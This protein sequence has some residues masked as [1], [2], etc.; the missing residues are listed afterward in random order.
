MKL[1]T[2]RIAQTVAQMQALGPEITQSR[3]VAFGE[4]TQCAISQPRPPFLRLG[5]LPALCCC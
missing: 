1:K 4:P 3:T 2:G 5:G